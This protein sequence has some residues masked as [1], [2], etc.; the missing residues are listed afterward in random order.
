MGLIFMTELGFKL[1][2]LLIKINDYDKCIR[3]FKCSKEEDGFA[4]SDKGRDHVVWIT[5]HLLCDM[6][7]SAWYFTCR[8]SPGSSGYGENFS[9]LIS[10]PW[11]VVS[12]LNWL[13][14]WV[15]RMKSAWLPS[16][17][18]RNLTSAFPAQ[19]HYTL[20]GH[21]ESLRTESIRRLMCSRWLYLVSKLAI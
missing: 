17:V 4:W 11:I 9:I 8:I 7:I 1:L 19:T 12:V 15:F 10:H 18:K 16:T 20:N 13:P 6:M 5:R 2:I 21:L 3:Q 14:P